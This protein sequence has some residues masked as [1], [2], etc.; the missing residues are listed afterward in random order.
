MN[1]STSRSAPSPLLGRLETLADPARLRLLHLLAD[2]ELTVS[3]L[4]DV[5]QLPQSTVSRH[6]KLLAEQGWVVSRAERTANFYRMANGELPETA[7]RLWELAAAETR[8]WSALAHDRLRLSRRLAKRS[9]EGKAFFAGVA[10]E[11]ERLRTEL[12]GARFTELALHALLPSDWVVADL[13]CGSGAVALSLAPW[14]RRVVAVDH[15]REM[16]AAARKRGAS[17]K[18][19]DWKQG[20]LEALPIADGACDAAVMLLALTHVDEPANAVAEM[21]RVVRPGGRA[22]VVDLLRHDREAFRRQMGQLRAG[23]EAGEL[24]EL[25]VTAGFGAVRCA[26][27]P[28]EPE[29]KGPALLVASVTREGSAPRK[30]S[31]STDSTGPRKSAGRPPFT[32]KLFAA[33]KGKPR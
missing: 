5:L 28:A 21:A 2:Q 31:R 32:S 9:G 20:E 17:T 8:D 22:V 11:W 27:L 26:P 23:F 18:N 12:Y 33:Q 19:V 1:H 24:A 14:V 15:S 25:L 29:A 7:Q 4:G 13:A 6:L 30:S 16:L 10:G 3:E